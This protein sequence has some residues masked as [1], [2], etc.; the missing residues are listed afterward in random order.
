MLGDKVAVKIGSRS[1][2]MLNEQACISPGVE[3]SIVN[4][5]KNTLD[6]AIDLKSSSYPAV[7][8]ESATNPLVIVA[9]PQEGTQWNVQSNEHEMA[10]LALRRLVSPVKGFELQ[11]M[12]TVVLRS[13]LTGRDQDI[14]L[15]ESAHDTHHGKQN[16]QAAIARNFLR[17]TAKIGVLTLEASVGGSRWIVLNHDREAVQPTT[18]QDG[19]SNEEEVQILASGLAVA[20]QHIMHAGVTAD[21]PEIKPADI[22][23]ILIDSSLEMAEGGNSTSGI[24]SEKIKTKLRSTKGRK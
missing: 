1:W 21:N 6:Q 22:A 20:V 16:A 11:H 13:L 23:G 2:F 12:L 17:G 24:M 3:L 9:M 5:G 4:T 8:A 19:M 18:I 14:P 15:I 7:V 10:R